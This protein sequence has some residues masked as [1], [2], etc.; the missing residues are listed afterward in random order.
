MQPSGRQSVPTCLPALQSWG[1]TE[2]CDRPAPTSDPAAFGSAGHAA[3]GG[4]RHEASQLRKPVFLLEASVLLVRRGV[5]QW[6]W[7]Y[8]L[9]PWAFAA[10]H[11]TEFVG[12]L[13]RCFEYFW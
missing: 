1:P 7:I 11:G 8:F 4:W 3:P 10:Q 13:G 6:G 12:L 9:P 2:S 5:A